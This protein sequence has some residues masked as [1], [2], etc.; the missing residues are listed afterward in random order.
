M[1]LLSYL[2][3]SFYRSTVQATK[4]KSQADLG[5]QTIAIQAPLVYYIIYWSFIFTVLRVSPRELVSSIGLT[6]ISLRFQA[7]C[8]QVSLIRLPSQVIRPLLNLI[9]FYLVN[10][11]YGFTKNLAFYSLVSLASTKVQSTRNRVLSIQSLIILRL[12]NWVYRRQ[13]SQ[14]NQS[15]LSLLMQYQWYVLN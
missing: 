11:S 15:I 13:G 14:V 8:S 4:D 10:Y 9:R 1:H 12:F 5:Q 3:F 2:I 6:I 7:W